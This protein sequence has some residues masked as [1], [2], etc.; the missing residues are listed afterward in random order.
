MHPTAPISLP[1]RFR[2]ASNAAPIFKLRFFLAG[3]LPGALRGCSFGCE[4]S[5]R[6]S[7][8]FSLNTFF[9]T[10][11]QLLGYI[12]AAVL[13]QVAAGVAFAFWRRAGQPP[14]ADQP[15]PTLAAVPSAV[16]AWAGW[17]AFRVARRVFEDADHTQCSFYLEPVDGK[18]L[19]PFNPG[20]FL[21]FQFQLPGASTGESSTAAPLR[22]VTR[23]YSLSDAPDPLGYRITV[24]RAAPPAA[25]PSLPAGVCS[26][27]WHTAMREGNVVQ[28]KAPAGRFFIDPD[29]AVPV[30]L[31]GGGIGITP[32]MS[33]ANWC[34]AEQPGRQ[35]HLY[36]G[37]GHGAELAFRSALQA[38]A[39]AHPHFHLHRV[40]SRPGQDDVQGRD[41]EHA[42]RVDVDLL[43]RTLPHGRH[44]FYVCGPPAMM[45]TL[46]PALAVWGVP[47]PDIHFEAFGPASVRLPGEASPAPVT[48]ELAVG[49]RRSG[50]S[51][52]WTG[53]DAN[54]L[55][56]AERHSVAVESGCRSGGCG[57]CQT[58][59][60]SGTVRY[61]HAPDFD[62]APGHCLLCV[63]TPTSAVVLEA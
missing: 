32:M 25:Q 10:A 57:S 50:R 18:L 2:L 55:D 49:F 62:I 40:F 38:L 56:F 17:R 8:A 34:L 15:T 33:M 30:V 37:V 14:S 43:K 63:G 45:E 31:I 20:Q 53:E 47:T 39:Q 42:G 7:Q 21:T 29:P 4:A 19:P 52:V 36:Y 27:H 3:N 28:V 46:V 48:T 41:F 22:T 61:D 59:L 5:A 13:L 6:S 16:G 54:L 35:V 12:G 26:S 58:R 60:V 44:Q 9:V 24:K 1:Q 51:L 23:C 11:L